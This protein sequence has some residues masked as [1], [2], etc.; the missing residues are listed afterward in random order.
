MRLNIP[1]TIIFE[2]LENSTKFIT[3]NQGGARSSK[4]YNEVLWLVRVALCPDIWKKYKV[5]KPIISICRETLPAL[6]ASAYR[7][8]LEIMTNNNIYNPKLMNKSDLIY[9]FETG[10]IIEFFS[11]DDPQK[12][13]SR[14]RDFLLVP[15][16]NENNFETIRQLLLRTKCKAIFDFN[17]SEDFWVYD[18]ILIRPDA[19]LFI[20]TYK[21]NPFLDERI[22]QEIE[23]LR[24]EDENA[25]KIYGL[26]E[27]GQRQELIYTNVEYLDSFDGI[28]FEE[29]IFGLDFGYNNPTA[30]I[31]ISLKDKC[32]YERE[33]LYQSFMTNGQLIEWLKN[34]LTMIQKRYCIYADA[35]EPQRIKELNDAGFYVKSADKS[36]KDGIDFCKRFKTFCLN[37][38][39]NNKKEKKNYSW[40]K[41]KNVIILDEPI[42]FNDHLC[43][44]SLYGIFTHYKDAFGKNIADTI[45]ELENQLTEDFDYGDFR[46]D[47]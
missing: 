32:F 14:K 40:K 5:N 17:P 31:E 21:N 25:W 37:S 42:K 26:G 33:V 30:L 9:Q 16:C 24:L 10:S 27:K 36:V 47:Y 20:S 39:I 2:N 22:K 4:T 13:K 19:E 41:D 43:D 29:T 6:K 38:D 3:V 34:N 44:A 1:T 8:F 18:K 35:A 28:E 46:D 12:L 23:M 45:S 15:E 7:D 11:L